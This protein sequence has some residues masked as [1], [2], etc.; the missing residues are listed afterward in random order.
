MMAPEPG[1]KARAS[2]V[3]VSLNRADERLQLVIEDNGIG[4]NTG[5]GQST[6]GHGLHN[7]RERAHALGGDIQFEPGA[8]RG[9][10]V[11]LSMPLGI[12]NPE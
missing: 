2:R 11:T 8:Y 10:R 7:M 1:S 5:R 3:D 6:G 9:T 12:K 4:L